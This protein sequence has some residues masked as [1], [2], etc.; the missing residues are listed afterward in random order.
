M[1]A[2]QR[3]HE[4][5]NDALVRISEHLWPGAKLCLVVYAEGRPSLDIVLKDN[6][7]S[8]DEV[9][10]TLRRAGLSIDGDNAYKRDLCD[11][12]VGSMKFGYDDRCP[13]P[14]D[15]WAH[16]FWGLGRDH[17][18]DRQELDSLLDEVRR[19]RRDAAR[20]N[21]L[22]EA[23]VESVHKGG[24]F[25]GLT[26]DNLVINGDDLDRRVDAL[27]DQPLNPA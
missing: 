8:L 10:S 22:R 25:A 6:G 20:Y 26:P 12:I 14:A 17:R 9:V 24:V 5:A 13:P 18:G 2:T 27:L 19:L 21:V 4:V 15:H 16:L 11:S 1:S 3:F 7:I 23:D